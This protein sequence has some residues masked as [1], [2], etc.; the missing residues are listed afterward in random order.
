MIL[1]L[2]THCEFYAITTR[3]YLLRGN[4]ETTKETACFAQHHV[5]RTLLRATDEEVIE[6]QS[7]ND[8]KSNEPRKFVYFRGS[9]LLL[10]YKY[11]RENL[12]QTIRVNPID[13]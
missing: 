12:H 8:H 3:Q 4:E 11:K 5:S 7:Q 2:R 6:P 1:P 10:E 9:L 13:A